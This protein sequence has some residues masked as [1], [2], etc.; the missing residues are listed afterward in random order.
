MNH[1]K[2]TLT[3][4]ERLN[5]KIVGKT[6]PV[7][8]P[9]KYQP[10]R[11]RRT[12]LQSA[13]KGHVPAGVIQLNKKPK[14]MEDLGDD[15]VRLIFEDGTGV[16]ADLVVGGDGIRSVVRDHIFAG[17]VIRFTGTIIWRVL[18]PV[19]EIKHMPELTVPTSW[20]RGPTGHVYDSF[21]DDPEELGEEERIFEIAA[22]N[23]VD[24][25]T[26]REKTFSWGVSATNERVE[27]HFVVGEAVRGLLRG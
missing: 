13:L 16:I 5:G 12:K 4:Q 27:S 14:R 19:A 2:L 7:G 23:A 11:V 17:H 21:V 25:E 10:R 20:W 26:V 18:I 1:L 22:R 24:P 9:V 6:G 15:G 3:L 8:L